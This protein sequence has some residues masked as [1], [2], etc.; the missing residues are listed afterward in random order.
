MALAIGMA[1]PERAITYTMVGDTWPEIRNRLKRM[2][3]RIREAGFEYNVAWHVEV[4]PRGTGHHVHGWQHG[5]YV[6]QRVHQGFAEREGMG[7][8]HLSR[9]RS[10]GPI[11]YG[12]KAATYG[13]KGVDSGAEVYLTTNGRR[14]VH[15]T[16]GFWRGPNGEPIRHVRNAVKWAQQV[17]YGASEGDWILQRERP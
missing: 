11:T 14:L 3:Y 4:N 7:I 10:V 16:R 17:R 13:L 6:S 15:A 8:T 9:V 5:S 1:A 2:H 12:M